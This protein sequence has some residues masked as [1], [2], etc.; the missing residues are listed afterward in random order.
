MNVHN[1]ACGYPLGPHRL[2][3]SN[4]YPNLCCGLKVGLKRVFNTWSCL[5]ND[6]PF[7]S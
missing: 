3:G 1:I 7:F 2:R 5:R 6:Y 4:E